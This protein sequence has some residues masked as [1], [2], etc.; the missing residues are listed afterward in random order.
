[1]KQSG[2][3]AILLWILIGAV[4]G[5]GIGV[6][7]VTG[8]IP[9][10]KMMQVTGWTIRICLGLIVL[11]ADVLCIWALIRRKILAAVEKNGMS[12]AGT[13]TAVREIPH[14]AHLNDD[15]WVRK[16]MFVFTVSYQAGGRTVT[17]EFTP[18]ALLSRREL[19]PL[20]AEIGSSLPVKY[21][22]KHPGLSLIDVDV[23]KQRMRED[24]QRSAKFF[25]IIPVILTAAWI[26]FG[27]V[28]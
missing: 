6:L 20:Q 8:V 22:R 3:K 14:P 7:G 4:I 25:V 9:G 21:S 18:T 12:A 16:A 26:V 15:D 24:Q 5:S 2:V 10:R 23:I 27:F 28:I 19:Y 13:V 11:L 17:K 1:M